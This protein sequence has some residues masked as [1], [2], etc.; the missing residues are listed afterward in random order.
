MRTGKQQA[1]SFNFSP[2]QPIF[3]L[4]QG[5]L[6]VIVSISSTHV[7]FVFKNMMGR[8]LAWDLKPKGVAIVSIHPGFMKVCM[9]VTSKRFSFFFFVVST[10]QPIE[11]RSCVTNHTRQHMIMPS[12]AVLNKREEVFFLNDI[13]SWLIDAPISPASDGHDFSL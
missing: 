6:V 4:A 7:V 12:C 13:L 3:L 2:A 1:T 11:H 9:P 10:L 5:D 8:L